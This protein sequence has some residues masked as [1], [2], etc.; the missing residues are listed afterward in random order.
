[1][2]F[3]LVKKINKSHHFETRFFLNVSSYT[4]VF[5]TQAVIWITVLFFFFYLTGKERGHKK[6]RQLSLG[7]LAGANRN[8]K[9]RLPRYLAPPLAILGCVV[10]GK[11]VRIL[12]SGDEPCHINYTQYS[13]KPWCWHPKE[14]TPW[15]ITKKKQLAIN[16]EAANLGF[17]PTLQTQNND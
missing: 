8:L 6:M 13:A 3:S 4:N 2:I 9:A 10:S 16:V 7:H 5:N 11:P 12:G 14:A 17:F 15:T 1:M